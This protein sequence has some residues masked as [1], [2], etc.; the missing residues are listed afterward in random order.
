MVLDVYRRRDLGLG[1][2]GLG[3]GLDWIGIGIVGEVLPSDV[4]VG[5]LGGG[6]GDEGVFFG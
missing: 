6:L 2:V 3:L 5:C 1:W 4:L